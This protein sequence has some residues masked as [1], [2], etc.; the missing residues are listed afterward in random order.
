MICDADVHFCPKHLFDDLKP[1]YPEFVDFYNELCQGIDL[2]DI[3]VEYYNKIKDPSWPVCDSRHGFKDLPIRIRLEIQES[4]KNIGYKL[5][6]VDSNCEKILLES[7][8]NYAPDLQVHLDAFALTKVD[9]QLLTMYASFMLMYYQSEKKFAVDM[10]HAWNSKIYKITNDYPDKFDAVAWLALQDLDASLVE[11]QKIIDQKFYAVQM[12]DHAHWSFIPEIWKIFE[13]CAKNKLPVFFHPVKYNP[14]PLPWSRD[15]NEN[16]IKLR[17]IYP[18]PTDGWAINI[19]G[20]VTEGVLEKYSDLKIIVAEQGIAWIPSMRE[21]MLSVGL[22]DPLPYFQKNFFF[23]VEPE[24]P[25]FL[26][27]ADLVGWNQ[28]IFSTDYPHND[29]GGRHRFDDVDLLN[30]FLIE[31]KIT[32]NQYDLL[33]HK[34]YLSLVR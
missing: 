28:L 24:D 13:I 29:P 12:H 16:Y 2:D 18:Y 11:L 7:Y 17:K 10:M 30:R 21:K 27:T 1:Q 20:M 4:L 8:N 26:K 32:Q 3:W 15:K 34:N 6:Q 9:R 5:F 22:P 25:Q 31:N 23:T 33:T 14:Y 19:A